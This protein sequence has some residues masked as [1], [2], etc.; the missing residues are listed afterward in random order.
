MDIEIYV[1]WTLVAVR[2]GRRCWFE[3][4]TDIMTLFK[5]L[6]APRSI[7]TQTLAS[8]TVIFVGVDE[9]SSPRNSALLLPASL[10]SLALMLIPMPLPARPPARLQSVVGVPLKCF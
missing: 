8:H 9:L 6:E 4:G 3:R 5:S 10:S 2:R 1:N 7:S